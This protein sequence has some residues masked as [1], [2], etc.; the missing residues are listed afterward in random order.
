VVWNSEQYDRFSS[1]RLRPA[2]ELLNRIEIDEP[3][4]VYDLGCGTGEITV[5]LTERYRG[6]RVVDLDSSEEMLEEAR[7][8]KGAALWEKADISGWK[9]PM[10]ADLIYSN[11]ALQW[12]GDH[13]TLFPRLLAELEIGGVLAVQVPLSWPQ[14]SLRLMRET[15]ES[16]G[17]GGAALG[18]EVL[19]SE[20]AR[21][22]VLDSADYYRILAPHSSALDVWTTEYLQVLEGT[23]PVF[24]WV[25]GTSLRPILNGLDK[26]ELTQFLECYR[27]RLQETYPRQEDG[28]TLYPFRR[29]F[30]VARR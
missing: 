19:R 3:R 30:L 2:L 21:P 17:Q 8:R 27:A 10:P 5:L 29:L 14:P 16:G 7:K 12:L 9:P 28:T 11:A 24:E 6:A 15:L 23:E 4:L 13:D 25:K 1:P 22:W 18:S 26:G 20:L